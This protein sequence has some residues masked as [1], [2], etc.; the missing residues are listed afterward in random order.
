VPREVGRAERLSTTFNRPP[1]TEL[2]SVGD[3]VGLHGIVQRSVRPRRRTAPGTTKPRVDAGLRH[4][5]RGPIPDPCLGANDGARTRD[6]L[7]H[8]Q[9]L[10]QLSYV[11]QATVRLQGTGLR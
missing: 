9:E 2:R 7:D 3:G 8:N 5:T 10:Y 6:R 11:R 1:T 4:C